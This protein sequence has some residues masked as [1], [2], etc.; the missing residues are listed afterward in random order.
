MSEAPKSG[1]SLMKYIEEQTGH[2]PSSGSIY[3]LLDQLKTAGLVDVKEKDRSKLYFL[4]L[5]GK[6]VTKELGGKCE[7]MMDQFAEGAKMIGA[8]TGE[9]TTEIESLI[10]RIRKGEMPFKQF[11]PELQ[12]FRTA[13]LHAKDPKRVKKIL[14]KTTQE[15]KKA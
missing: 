12:K 10:A 1:Y 3:P 9:D 15:I 8:I 13:L 11:N 7:T 6:K 5:K 2:R 14:A 4:T